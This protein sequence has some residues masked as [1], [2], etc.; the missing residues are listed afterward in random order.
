VRTPPFLT[1]AILAVASA[2]KPAPQTFGDAWYAAVRSR[3]ATAAWNLIDQASRARI[4]GALAKA[5]DKAAKDAAFA[6]L[7]KA[8]LAPVDPALAPEEMAKAQLASQLAGA[9]AAPIAVSADARVVAGSRTAGLH[10]ESRAWHA[11]VAALGFADSDGAPV[12][13]SLVLPGASD[14]P[15]PAAATAQIPRPAIPSTL[16]F[17]GDPASLVRVQE[18]TTEQKTDKGWIRSVVHKAGDKTLDYTNRNLE[19]GDFVHN[20]LVRH[21]LTIRTGAVEIRFRMTDDNGAMVPSLWH[22]QFDVVKEGGAE[23]LYLRQTRYLDENGGRWRA[24]QELPADKDAAATIV[25]ELRDKQGEDLS[26]MTLEQRQ[27][28]LAVKEPGR[29]EE[30]PI[31]SVRVSVERSEALRRAAELL[32]LD[33]VAAGQA[34]ALARVWGGRVGQ[35]GITAIDLVLTPG[36]KP[37]VSALLHKVDDKEEQTPPLAFGSL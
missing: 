7:A 35:E 15:A 27:Q 25:R 12:C 29:W 4:L 23:V 16:P 19:T 24:V 34:Q 37:A 22:Q 3:D 18:I 30:G 31:L 11:E 28:A 9:P 1:V 17:E 21:Q 6:A 10:L 20:D 14:P 36:E 2:C 32:K 33:P 8:C 26:K 5:H 13:L